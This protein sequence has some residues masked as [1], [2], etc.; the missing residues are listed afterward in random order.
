MRFILPVGAMTLLCVS[1]NCTQGKPAAR[2]SE[3]PFQSSEAAVATIEPPAEKAAEKAAEKDTVAVSSKPFFDY[4]PDR[5]RILVLYTASVQGYVEPCGCTGDPLG[6][7]ARWS[8]AVDEA[9]ASY[10]NRVL[11]LDAGGLLFEK[12]DDTDPIDACQTRARHE[13][14]LSTYSRKGVAATVLGPRDLVR[15]VAWRN[16][17]FRDRSISTVD[18]NN[19]TKSAAKPDEDV[20]LT[21][22][23]IPYLIQDLDGL[24]V[25]I[26]GFGPA[27]ASSIDQ[28]KTRLVEVV[29]TLRGK[30]ARLVIALSQTPRRVTEQIGQ[31]IEGLD[32]IIQGHDPGE[33]PVAPQRLGPR[34]PVLTAA[35]MQAQY[36]GS[37][38]FD[39]T[40]HEGNAPLVLDDRADRK[41]RRLHL[42]AA[43]IKEYTA[44]VADSEEGPRRDF[45][46]QKR[47]SAIAEQQTL[48]SETGI[49]PAPIEPHLTVRALP[50]SRTRPEEKEAKETLTSY[51][52]AIPSLTAQ[53]EANAECPQPEAGQ[54]IYV[55]VQACYGCHQDAV[56]FWQ[57]QTVFVDGV[58]AYGKTIQRE[59]GHS[60]A[61][62][63]LEDAMK[64]QD[65]TC[66][67]CHSIGFNAAGGYCRVSE[68]DFRKNVQCESCHGPGSLHIQNGGDPSSLGIV[69]VDEQV[70]RSCHHVPHIPTTESF[71]FTEKLKLILGPGHGAER[72][73]QLSGINIS[74]D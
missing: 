44:R 53:C 59:L 41:A 16:D 6:G 7:I 65:R 11:L 33:L 67:G 5:E 36:L 34:G 73:R 63:T 61:W 64:T 23:P 62:A 17:L 28:S 52:K 54:P 20:L 47:D 40:D 8:A 60:K 1:L 31:N 69:N 57:N 39:I 74:H 68:V 45:L 35:G 4:I 70:C 24:L 48:Q 29:K 26:T 43:R 14:L 55:G 22:Q 10:G 49:Q 13:A 3:K 27:A 18:M 58:D 46:I 32:L 51:E 19:H 42:L 66:V 37:V 56:K 72:L 30:G 21:P 38:E 9:R 71:V 15:G 12:L 25:G 50:L 2:E